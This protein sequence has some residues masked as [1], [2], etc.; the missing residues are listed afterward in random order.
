MLHTPTTA[1]APTVVRRQVLLCCARVW[2]W[3]VPL[4]HTIFTHLDTSITYYPACTML[5]ECRVVVIAFFL[6]L[7][8]FL[9]LSLCIHRL[10]VALWLELHFCFAFVIQ[11]GAKSGQ[12]SY[13]LSNI[14][15]RAFN[16]FETNA[17]FI[18]FRTPVFLPAMLFCLRCMCAAII[19]LW[20]YVYNL[21]MNVRQLG[22]VCVS[23]CVFIHFFFLLLLI[24]SAFWADMHDKIKTIERKRE[25]N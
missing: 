22:E 17:H 9:S 21:N 10:L 11:S 8:L 16:A 23:V 6:D 25:Q 3:L 19:L 7:L 15:L 4:L 20:I 1:T 14:I 13:L 12:N 18:L 24:L 2:V 5:N